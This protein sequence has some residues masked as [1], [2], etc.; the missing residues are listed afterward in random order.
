MKT[1][2][3]CGSPRKNGH[4][5]DLINRLCKTLDHEY[6]IIWSYDQIF[7]PCIDCRYCNIKSGCKF[8]DDFNLFLKKLELCDNFI[9]ASPLHFGSLTG[10][11]MSF[12]SRFQ[13]YFANRFLRVDSQK[14]VI[15]PKKVALIL[16]SGQG[17]PNVDYL[18]QGQY[19]Y[20]LG[21]VC[22]TH[23]GCIHLKKTDNL[24]DD[25]LSSAYYNIDKLANSLNLTHP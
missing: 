18:A 2:I 8:D 1:L 17:F 25:A 22:G 9:I 13:T 10:Q 12:F 24:T 20:I 6:E 4:S 7:S 16:T 23:I 15:N 3:I 19:N 11:L 5:S 21:E 14:I